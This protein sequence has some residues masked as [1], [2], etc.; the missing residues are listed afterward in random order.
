MNI[1]I[2]GALISRHFAT[3]TAKTRIGKAPRHTNP[4]EI[5][6]LS[7]FSTHLDQ[8]I[9]YWITLAIVDQTRQASAR[10]FGQL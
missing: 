10:L 5:H 9:S 7:T 4:V 2:I 8:D 6:S 1:T 3:K